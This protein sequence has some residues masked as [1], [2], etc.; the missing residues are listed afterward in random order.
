M[1]V[2]LLQGSALNR[3]ELRFVRIHR[4]QMCVVL[5]NNESTTEDA[6]LIDKESI[7]CTLNIKTMKFQTFA[8][9]IIEGIA[10]SGVPNKQT[11]IYRSLDSLQVSLNK[12]GVRY[13]QPITILVPSP[14]AYIAL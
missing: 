4:C 13:S 3:S 11:F 14:S 6:T 7:L 10:Y 5:T 8:N 12:V 1:V 2:V 9:D